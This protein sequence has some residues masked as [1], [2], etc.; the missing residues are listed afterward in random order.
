MILPQLPAALSIPDAGSAAVDAQHI[1][2]LASHALLTE[3]LPHGSHAGTVLSVIRDMA[4]ILAWN[5]DRLHVE[6]RGRP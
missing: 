2:D 1:A 3:K 4:E 5:L 6:Q